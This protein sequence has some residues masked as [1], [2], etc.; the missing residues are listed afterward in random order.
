MWVCSPH[1]TEDR[2]NARAQGDTV[3]FLFFTVADLERELLQTLL[4]TLVSAGTEKPR[5]VIPEMMFADF[6]GPTLILRAVPVDYTVAEMRRKLVN[7]Y[8]SHSNDRAALR[9]LWKGKQLEDG[10][11]R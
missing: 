7:D 2:N 11:F 6:N 5:E 9:F 4:P 8:P 3:D 10:Q 1:L